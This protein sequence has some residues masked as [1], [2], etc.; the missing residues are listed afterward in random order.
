[1][2]LLAFV[3]RYEAYIQTITHIF[4]SSGDYC[5]HFGQDRLLSPVYRNG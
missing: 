3:H 1:M 5:A 2:V 4:A